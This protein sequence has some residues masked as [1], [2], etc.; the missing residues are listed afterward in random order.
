[1]LDINIS[2]TLG[3]S[4]TGTYTVANIGRESEGNY[5]RSKLQHTGAI[6]RSVQPENGQFETADL[7][8]SLANGDL[9]FSKWPWNTSILNRPAVLRMGFSGSSIGGPTGIEYLANGDYL[10]DG[11]I[12]AS[13]GPYGVGSPGDL[14]V[15]VAYTL[16]KGIIKKEERS[17]KEFKLS[18]GDYTHRIF[19]DIPPRKITV[20]E[21]PYIGTSVM[22]LGTMTDFDTDLVGKKIP[23]IWGDFTDSPLIQPLFID[24]VKHR[25]LFA[26]HA[27]GTVVKVYS[28]GTQVYN[29][30]TYISGTH[31][32]TNIMSFID[33]G[34]SQGTSFVYAEIRGR[35]GLTLASMPIYGT[36]S[37]NGTETGMEK[38]CYIG[39]YG[40]GFVD[41][42][43]NEKINYG[44]THIVYAGCWIKQKQAT[45][46]MIG[47]QDTNTNVVHWGTSG[48]GTTTWEWLSMYWPKVGTRGYKVIVRAYMQSTG[49]HFDGFR[50][51]IGTALIPTE[52]GDGTGLV[53]NGDFDYWT[54]GTVTG[55]VAPDGWNSF[56]S[57]SPPP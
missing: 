31:T 40:L 53:T 8:V 34:T 4:A 9:E 13:G 25:Y 24:T 51:S 16:Y 28:G 36:V 38:D 39:P 12:L 21:F 41:V 55:T 46:A 49:V 7:S 22:I 30:T 54:G 42:R 32:G 48:S 47:I 35:E 56:W 27:I 52:T 26:D 45:V 3:E 23:Y 43:H 29:F 11:S 44:G 37:L 57:H 15:A 10:A 6:N 14:S 2:G 18:I 19:R 17:N 33:F 1:M 20:T 50:T 5:Y